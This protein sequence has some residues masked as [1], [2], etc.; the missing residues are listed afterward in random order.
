MLRTP[1]LANALL[2]A[3]ALFLC[4]ACAEKLPLNL[5]A[6]ELVTVSSPKGTHDLTPAGEAHRRLGA[7]L[8]G[9][10]DGWT[11]Y[12]ATPPAGDVFVKA[13]G[14]SLQFRGQ[15]VLAYTQQGVFSKAIKEEDYAFLSAD[16]GT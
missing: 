15:T 6:S 5:G 7:W 11:P 3:A 12:R 8:A 1:V 16:S 4:S 9:N 10:Q 2:V 14:L 13:S